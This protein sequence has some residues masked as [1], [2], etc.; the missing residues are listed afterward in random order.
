MIHIVDKQIFTSISYGL[1]SAVIRKYLPLCEACPAGNMVRRPIRRTSSDREILPGEEIQVDIKLML[2]ILK[3]G[4]T[5]ALLEIKQEPLRRFICPPALN[6]EKS[7]VHINP[8]KCNSKKFW[9][10]SV[11][12]P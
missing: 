9:L 6:L 11:P 3:P 4:S 2:T 7:F 10:K 5:S 1:T 12:V 8:S